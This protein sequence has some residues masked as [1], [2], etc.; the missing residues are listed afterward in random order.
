MAGEAARNG[1]ESEHDLVAVDGVDVEVH[2]HP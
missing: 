1:T 2:R